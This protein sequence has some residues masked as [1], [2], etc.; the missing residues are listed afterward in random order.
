MNIEKKKTKN[1]MTR[2][3]KIGVA[4]LL[5]PAIIHLLIFWLGVQIETIGMAFT[6]PDTG[7]FTLDNFIWSIK[8]L[9]LGASASDM[10]LAFKNTMTFF[11]VALCRV[12]I[13]IFF[14]YLIFRKSFGHTFMRL[15]LYLPG[16]I[17]GIMMAMLYT[18]IMASDGPVIALVQKLTGT[19]GTYMFMV[20]HPMLYIIIFDTLVGIGGNLVIWLGSMGRIPNDLIEY[21]KLEG[22]GPLR[23]FVSVVLPLIWPTFVTMISMQIIGI[24][25][26]SG[27]VMLL[28]NGQYGTDTLAFWM[29]RVAKDG[30][31]S[32]YH[33]VSAA[34]LIFTFLTIPILIVCRKIMN[35]F[36]EEVEY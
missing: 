35:R 27:A 16:A 1:R 26:A 10:G 14:A 13:G 22:I 15:G 7:Q 8:E 4:I 25:G 32:Q 24:F 17:S 31:A 9:F 12:P 20:E 6:K 11:V 3:E 30:I 18:K 33:V 34:G 21:G 19:S 36:G 29:Y 28:T 2:E 5:A 23:E